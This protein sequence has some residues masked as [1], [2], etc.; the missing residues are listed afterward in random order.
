MASF[1]YAIVHNAFIYTPQI[2]GIELIE[3]VMVC[4]SSRL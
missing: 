4:F 1:F 2:S 3:N